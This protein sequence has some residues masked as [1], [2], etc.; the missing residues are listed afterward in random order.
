LLAFFIFAGQKDLGFLGKMYAGY[1]FA[2]PFFM[3]R[4]KK[5]ALSSS[6]TGI[7]L[8]SVWTVFVGYQA[9]RFSAWMIRVG[10]LQRRNE[11][12]TSGTSATKNAA[13]NSLSGLATAAA[14]AM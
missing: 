11:L 9:F 10:F 14:A 3:M 1:F 7:G 2:M 4:V 8:T 5:A 12:K 6:Y 13:A